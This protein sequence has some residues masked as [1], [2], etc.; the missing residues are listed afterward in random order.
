MS[1]KTNTS[2]NASSRVSPSFDNMT[3]MSGLTQNI[4]SCLFAICFNFEIV[5]QYLI[6]VLTVLFY[7]FF[8]LTHIF[9]N[10]IVVLY[11]EINVFN[12][13]LCNDGM[14]SHH[15]ACTVH[16]RG[17]MNK[18]QIYMLTCVNRAVEFL[19]QQNVTD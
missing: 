19:T 13:L 2:E 18:H 15:T 3:M 14:T 12:I 6:Y 5:L 1:S 7:N 17:S 11:L 16:F 10:L 8:V 4:L 9:F